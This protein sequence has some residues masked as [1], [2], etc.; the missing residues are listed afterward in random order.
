MSRHEVRRKAAI[1]D[2][3]CAERI[4]L[5]RLV[6]VS[7]SSA[8]V[9]HAIAADIR[10]CCGHHPLKCHRLA[11]GW[12]SAEKAVRAMHDMCRDKELGAHQALLA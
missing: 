11:Y 9:L 8:A 4:R 6:Q 7:E 2:A 10:T 3:M 1:H 12:S 5:R